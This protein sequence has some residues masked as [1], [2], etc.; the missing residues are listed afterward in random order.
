MKPEQAAAAARAGAAEQRAQGAY[1]DDLRSVELQPAG[2]RV[3]SDQLMEWAL[4]EPDTELVVSTRRWG[5]PISWF[6]RVLLHVMRQY[7]AQLESQQTRFNVHL[8]ARV[9]EQEERLAVME[10][11]LRDDSPDETP[12]RPAGP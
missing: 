4:I 2:E 1:S 12:F 6:K 9:V 10:E 7:L 8:L 3:T 11:W 5:A